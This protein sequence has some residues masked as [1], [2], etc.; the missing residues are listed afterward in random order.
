MPEISI[1]VPVYNVE[2]YLRRCVDSILAQTFT[3][4]ELLLID[5]GSPDNSG[6]ICD[7]YAAKDD[8]IRVFHKEND[9]VSSARNLGL[10]K[11]QGKY[12]GFVDGDD[13]VHEHFLT[14]LHERIAG[15]DVVYC[16]SIDFGD[17]CAFE[18][19]NNVGYEQVDESF[20]FDSKAYCVVWNKLYNRNAI[21]LFRFDESLNNGEDTLFSYL[22]L[23]GCS[24]IGHVKKK[25]YG[26]FRRDDSATGTIG[27]KGRKD[28]LYVWETIYGYEKNKG[29]AAFFKNVWLDSIVNLFYVSKTE[30]REVYRE[31]RK[32][33]L[34]NLAY[35]VSNKFKGY[36][37]R[38]RI[39]LLC[40][41]LS[42]K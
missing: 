22:V 31:C 36:G 41:L 13:I 33:I 39:S 20:I 9:G 15:N 25:L 5:D 18:T 2:K 28:I 1:I 14:I 30:D 38:S 29:N 26:Y 34:E 27:L 35:C 19:D 11:A 12:I 6:A 21:D 4:F 40:A 7:E 17:R 42:S 24:R 8:R 37:L 3:D 23:S 16:D 10:D 32:I